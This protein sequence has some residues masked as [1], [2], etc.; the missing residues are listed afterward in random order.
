MHMCL[1]IQYGKFYSNYEYVHKRKPTKK[2]MD[3]LA[4]AAR[5][6]C[7]K[8]EHIQFGNLKRGILGRGS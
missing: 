6:F 3:A 1:M 2:V 7:K 8:L 5:N 4:K